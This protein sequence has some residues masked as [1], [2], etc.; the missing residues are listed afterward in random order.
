MKL[1]IATDGTCK[2]YD[3]AGQ[4]MADSSTGRL[5][6]YFSHEENAKAWA[7]MTSYGKEGAVDA[8]F[9]HAKHLIDAQEA[10]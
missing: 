10:R 2:L 5:I 6:R 7:K 4:L 3:E 1:E 8:A 9:K